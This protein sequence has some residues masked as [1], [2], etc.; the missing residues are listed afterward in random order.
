M[1]KIQRHSCLII[2]ELE[3][4]R[5]QRQDV[6]QKVNLRCFKLVHRPYSNSFNL[7]IVG[8]CFQELKSKGLFL[9]SQK[10]KENRCL[11]FTYVFHKREIRKIHVV[12]VQR[13]QRKAQKSV[14]HVQSCCFANLNLYCFL[15]PLVAIEVVVA[16]APYCA[17]EYYN[18]HLKNHCKCVAWLINEFFVI[19][20]WLWSLNQLTYSFAATC[21]V[22]K[23]CRETP[24][25]LKTSITARQSTSGIKSFGHLYY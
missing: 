9:S 6:T 12:V 4:W 1:N 22:L 3:Q 16:E 24:G 2:R 10:E 7:S 20:R 18:T 15:A 8:D 23:I 19:L 13:R 14:L 11:V 21:S 17:N 5:Q 25:I